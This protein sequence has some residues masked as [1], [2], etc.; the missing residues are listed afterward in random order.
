MTAAVETGRD[1]ASVPSVV[2]VR[3]FVEGAVYVGGSYPRLRLPQSPFHNPFRI[4]RDGTRAEILELYPLR[5]LRSPTLLA[6]L[7]DLRGK[8]LAC[9]CRHDG[10]TRPHAPRCHADVLCE[11]LAAYYDDELRD[12][13]RNR[14][15]GHP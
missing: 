5:L 6:M 10:D 12:M 8:P 2:H 3:D 7:P 1:R 13:A 15:G 9:S 4:G 11:L 14:H